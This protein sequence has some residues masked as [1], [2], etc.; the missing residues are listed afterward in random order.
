MPRDCS[1]PIVR[2]PRSPS[3]HFDAPAWD[4]SQV[5]ATRSVVARIYGN[6]EQRVA[7]L[8]AQL[9]QVR[10]ARWVD[11]P[12]LVA[13]VGE[14]KARP[15]SSR[16]EIRDIDTH[17]ATRPRALA[18]QVALENIEH[19]R[20]PQWNLADFDGA[21]LYEALMNQPTKADIEDEHSR[22]RLTTTSCAWSVTATVEAAGR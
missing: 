2:A 8:Q 20:V 5:Y 15:S 12:G 11:V 13:L 3:T 17:P 7:A 21:R 14:T 18:R 4:R 9:E 10:G 1:T 19:L 22:P 16:P 6:G